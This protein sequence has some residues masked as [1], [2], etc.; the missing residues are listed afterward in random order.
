MIYSA[1]SKNFIRVAP[2]G[3]IVLSKRTNNTRYVL[4]CVASWC[5]YCKRLLPVV[6]DL[7]RHYKGKTVFLIAEETKPDGKALQKALD[8]QAYPTVFLINEDGSINTENPVEG[9]SF[10]ELRDAFD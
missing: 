10:E 9:R 3:E 1:G 2:L 8:V 4:V 7:D 5:G 6:H